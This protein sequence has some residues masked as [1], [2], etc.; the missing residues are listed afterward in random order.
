MT[1]PGFGSCARSNPGEIDVAEA[2]RRLEALDGDDDAVDA[3]EGDPE[4]P[5]DDA[6]HG[7][8]AVDPGT[9]TTRYT[10]PGSSHA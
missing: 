4:L 8:A 1:T 7:S 3:V 9:E 10:D 6:T 2:G 5:A